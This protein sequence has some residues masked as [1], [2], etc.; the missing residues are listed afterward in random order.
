MRPSPQALH[1]GNVEKAAVRNPDPPQLQLGRVT[2]PVRPNQVLAIVCSRHGASQPRPVHRQRRAA[3][4]R[5]GLSRRGPATAVLDP[6]RLRHRLCRT[7]GGF[8]GRLAERY[9]R[10]VSFLLG[11]ALFTLSSAACAAATSVVMLVAV[12]HRPSRRRRADDADVARLASG[13]LLGR[14]ARSC[15]PDLDRRRRLCRGARSRGRWAAPG[16]EW[17]LD[18]PRQRPHRRAGPSRRPQE[19]AEHSRSRRASAGRLGCAARHVRRRNSELRHHEVRRVGLGVGCHHRD[20][21]PRVGAPHVVRR[22]LPTVG[23]PARRPGA[24]GCFASRRSPARP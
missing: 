8:F 11:I 18:L 16:L 22:R 9:R 14:P 5:P 12:S 23:Q 20:A 24:V 7:V 10:D 15:C 13:D 3:R 17:A 6:E 2:R 19:A 21:G 4:H 1:P